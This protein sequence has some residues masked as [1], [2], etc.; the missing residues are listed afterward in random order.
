MQ[1]VKKTDAIVLMTKKSKFLTL[2]FLFFF[3]EELCIL[4]IQVSGKTF[5]LGC[6]A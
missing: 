2:K 5:I 3:L 1:L 4:S 6:S